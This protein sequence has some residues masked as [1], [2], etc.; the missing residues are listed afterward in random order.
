MNR[1]LCAVACCV[2]LSLCAQLDSAGAPRTERHHRIQFSSFAA[3]QSTGIENGLVSAMFAGGE[4]SR[5]LRQPTLDRLQPANR[6][7]YGLGLELGYTWKAGLFGSSSLWPRISAAYRDQLGVAFSRDAFQVSFF[8]NK[9]FEG[10]TAELGP[11]RFDRQVYQTLAFGVGKGP[12]GPYVEL[13]LVAGWQLD[14]GHVRRASLYTAPLGEFLEVDLDGSYTR[15]DTARTNAPRGLGGVINAGW[16]QQI[17]FLGNQAKFSIE[18]RDVGLIAWGASSLSVQKDSLI[19]FDGFEIAGILDLDELVLNQHSLQDSLGLGYRA[20]PVS[21]WLPAQLT[22]ALEFGRA[23]RSRDG[24]TMHPYRLLAEHR[25][26]PGFL[27]Y[28]MAQRRFFVSDAFTMEGGVAAGG[29]GGIQAVFGASIWLGH[30]LN[31]DLFTHNLGGFLSD[32]ATGKSLG[33]RLAATW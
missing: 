2:P 7:G 6:A 3:Y 28:A 23:H 13:G 17:R 33:L 30:S 18:A 11:G 29:F 8:G 25:F 20:A 4:V 21:T 10:R 27:P 19:H 24:E 16:S 22:A 32:R 1:L 12:L 31:L 26:I 9:A 15:S 14:Q 5:E